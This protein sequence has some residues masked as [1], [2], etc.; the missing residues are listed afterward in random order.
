MTERAEARRRQATYDLIV[1]LAR[2]T[3]RGGPDNRQRALA[4]AEQYDRS[5]EWNAQLVEGV[6]AEAVAE[7][8][9]ATRSAAL[10]T[11]ALNG[12]KIRDLIAA[13]TASSLEPLTAAKPEAELVVSGELPVRPQPLEPELATLRAIDDVG[14]WMEAAWVA[15]EAARLTHEEVEAEEWPGAEPVRSWFTCRR[16]RGV[17]PIV[18]DDGSYAWPAEEVAEPEAPKTV[19][20]P[21][22]VAP[23]V[24]PEP[25]SLLDEAI[26]AMNQQH[27]VIENV[28]GKTVIASW[29]PASHD[30][31]RLTVVFQGKESFLLRYSNRSIGWEIPNGKGGKV[32]MDAPIGQF[33]LSHRDRQQYRGVTFLPDGPRVVHGCLN[34]WQGWGVEDRPED[35]RLIRE[36][37]EEVV[38]GGNEEFAEYV[39]RWIAWSIQNP[40]AQAEVALV[41]IGAK[42]A[43]KGT[44]VRCLERIF[45]AHAFQVTS[46]EE[47]IGKFNGHLQDCVL[48]VADEAY[49]GGDKRCVG[50]LQGMITEPTLP[51]ERKGIDLI[52]VRNYLH[53]V[54]LAEPGWVIPAGRYERRYAALAVSN[55]RR[56][57]RTYFRAL[58]QQIDGGGAEG[59]FH[60]LRRMAL[61]DWHPREIPEALLTNPE[62]QKQ[63]R[64]TLPP[65][66][67]WFLGLLH[68]GVLPGAL[69]KRPNTAYTRGLIDDAKERF[70]RLKWD[71]T[72]VSLQQFLTD[73]ERA[74]IPCEK[75]RDAKAN[76]WS[77]APLAELRE[78]WS[79]TWGAVKW[80]N[81][82][83]EWSKRNG[84]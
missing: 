31:E 39:I 33:W 30:L 54:M 44:L 65:M 47:V 59:M 66:E 67:Q 68:E 19:S 82:A 34:L 13:K 45:G 10:Q 71:L 72:D 56:G 51:I 17:W 15:V 29:E 80:D 23:S 8:R 5:P 64:H 79:R 24:L 7:Q 58:H 40:A 28:G 62:L 20:L 60:E 49:W 81:P 61:G 78:A 12:K 35:W 53:V 50:R 37:I 48:F 22:V 77:F 43:G 69:A 57:D 27:A 42:G 83:E 38:A 41:L 63:Q 14:K 18:N 46:R 2:E 6:F 84:G 75:H 73:P 76:G 52:Q 16:E 25:A 26:R 4:A 21:A 11:I 36:H 32:K 70:P 9:A 3:A 74:G 55:S 1:E